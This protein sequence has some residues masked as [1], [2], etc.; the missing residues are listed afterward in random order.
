MALDISK[1][2]L[3]VWDLDDTFWSGTISEG[4]IKPSADNIQLVRDLTDC[5]IIN[6]ICSKNDFE[7][8]KAE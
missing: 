1:I 8:V 6:S 4:E 2:K 5:G 3:V 7:V